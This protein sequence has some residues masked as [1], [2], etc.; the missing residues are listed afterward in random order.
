MW[1]SGMGRLLWA[2][3]AWWRV[4]THVAHPSWQEDSLSLGDP[5]PRPSPSKDKQTQKTRQTR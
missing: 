3:L 5:S 4:H 2:C 1:A